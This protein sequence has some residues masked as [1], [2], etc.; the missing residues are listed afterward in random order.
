MVSLIPA[1]TDN[2]FFRRYVKTLVLGLRGRKASTV[3]KLASIIFF[4]IHVILL[5]RRIGLYLQQ[6]YINFVFKK[7]MSFAYLQN[8]TVK[9]LNKIIRWDKKRNIKFRLL[10]DLFTYIF[11]NKLISLERN[12]NVIM[13]L[14]R[15]QMSHK[16]YEVLS[17]CLSVG[18]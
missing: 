10:K 8:S 17:V 3:S 16:G 2:P 5:E 11:K 14:F 13:R 4:L 15:P 9:V 18:P 12:S 6:A 1:I 7:S